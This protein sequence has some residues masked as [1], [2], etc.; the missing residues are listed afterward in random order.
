MYCFNVLFL[1]FSV[2]YAVPILKQIL[3]PLVVMEK[4][5]EALNCQCAYLASTAATLTFPPAIAL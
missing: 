5:G 3:V 4:S 1:L 2:L